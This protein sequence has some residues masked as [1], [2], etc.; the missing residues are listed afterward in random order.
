MEKVALLTSG[1]IFLIVS[2]LHLLRA[3]SNIE[4]KIGNYLLPRWISIVGFILP[5]LLSVW[6]FSLVKV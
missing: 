3:I 2:I 5:F 1:I 6:L 4:V